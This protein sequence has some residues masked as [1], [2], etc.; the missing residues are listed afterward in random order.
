MSLYGALFSGVSGLVAQSS[1]MGAI[2]DNI[3]NVSTVGYK[4]TEVHFQ[5]LVTKQTSGTFYSAGGVQSKPRQSTD[6]QGLL[7]ASTSQTDLAVSGDGFFVVNSSPTPGISDEYLYT[8]SGSFYQDDQGYLK[9]SQGYYLQGWPTDA[10]GVVKTANSDLTVTNQNIISTDYLSTINLNRVGGTAASTNTVAI[11]ANLPSSAVE[12]DSYKTDVQF[13]NSL[14][15]ANNISVNYTKTATG[16]QWQLGI[17]PPAGTAV[18]TLYDDASTPLVYDSRGQIEFTAIPASGSTIKIG[19]SSGTAITYTFAASDAGTSIDITG[20]TLAQVVSALVADIKANDGSFAADTSRVAVKTGDTSALVFNES[21]IGDIYVDL[22]TTLS[23]TGTAVTK[24]TGSFTVKQVDNA[25]STHTALKFPQTPADTEKLVINGITYE[26]SNSA[27]WTVP[28]AQQ[29]TIPA[30]LSATA[31]NINTMMTNLEAAI[32][33]SDTVLNTGTRLSTVDLDNDGASLKDTLLIDTVTND[34][35]DVDTSGLTAAS[36]PTYGQNGTFSSTTVSVSTTNGLIFSAD[37]VPSDIN[38]LSL[39]VLNFTDGAQNMSGSSTEGKRI[40][41]DFG[42][43]GEANGMTQFGEEFTPTF[44]TQNGSKFGTF[45]GVTVGTDGLVTALF[46]NGE[47]RKIFKIPMATF[48]NANQLE[49]KSGNVWSATQ[50]S[51]DYTLREPDSGSAGQVIQSA[52]ESSTVDIGTE[53]T[54]MIVVQRAYSASTKI[55]S[56]ADQMLEELMRV[57]R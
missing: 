49:G 37:G 56:T 14:G 46:D 44:I 16:N 17:D 52:L 9:N 26:F 13:F 27:T 41:L 53:F 20:K 19:S 22:S 48:V 3:T 12:A 38:G 47:T 40:T 42:T 15:N 54:N 50:F 21:G 23:S 29:V 7:Q 8:R 57:K 35:N 55:I 39:E 24:Q 2:S 10:S 6:V 43:V 4:S 36:R 30:A 45:A 11:G 18:A 31:A 34:T 33:A 28:A 32:R 1:A 25:Y 5:T 51:G